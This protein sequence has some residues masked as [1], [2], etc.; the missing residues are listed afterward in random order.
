MARGHCHTLVCVV[1]KGETTTSTGQTTPA[2]RKLALADRIAGDAS[3]RPAGAGL[4]VKT[5]D[6]RDAG[7]LLPATRGV[8]AERIARGAVTD[9][10]AEGRTGTKARVVAK[11]LSIVIATDSA[12]LIGSRTLALVVL[13]V[14]RARASTTSHAATIVATHL[15]SATPHAG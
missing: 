2:K 14:C 4:P 8:V 6:G 11:R 15:P 12:A 13:A 7:I 10:F 5:V 3:L 9:I 1:S